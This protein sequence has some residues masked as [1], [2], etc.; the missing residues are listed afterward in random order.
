M[1]TNDYVDYADATGAVMRLPVALGTACSARKA[2]TD[3]TSAEIATMVADLPTPPAGY[4]WRQKNCSITDGPWLID[5]NQNPPGYTPDQN[6]TQQQP[7]AI[8]DRAG[9]EIVR[10]SQSQT[11]AL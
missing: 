6:P 8:G 1:I 4:I 11:S 9:E 7:L 3:L 2:P 10:Y 5:P